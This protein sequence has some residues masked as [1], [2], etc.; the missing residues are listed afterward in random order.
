VLGF[1][2]LNKP[3]GLTS[4]DCVAKIRR[5]LKI[6]RVGHGGTLDPAATGVLPIAVG[7]ATRLLSYLPQQKAY[8]ATVRFGVKTTT[9]DLEGE[10]IAKIATPQLTLQEILPLLAQFKGKVQQIPPQYS[11]IQRGGKRLY[12]LARKGEKVEVPSRIVAIN[13]I[14]V[15]GFQGGE[16]PELELNINCGPG[17]YIRAIARD[18]GDILG[19]GGTLAS[20]TRTLSCGLAI[21]NSLSFE[22]IASQLKTGEFEPIPPAIALKHLSKIILSAEQSRRWCMGQRL[23]LNEIQA[24]ELERDCQ[25]IQVIDPKRIFLGLGNI[26][27]GTEGLVLTPKI[28]IGSVGIN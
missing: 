11:A 7:S 20:L 16:Y 8:R 9:D 13:G 17:T 12:E 27:K 2:N 18:L 26:I 21:E 4:H 23:S 25:T 28:V 3:A 10:I 6:K 14:E 15:L 24:I 5:Q 22:E 19:V 1:L